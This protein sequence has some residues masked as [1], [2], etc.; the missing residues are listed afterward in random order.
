MVPIGVITT[1]E[2]IKMALHSVETIT[3]KNKKNTSTSLCNANQMHEDN[4]CNVIY[5][6]SL[7]NMMVIAPIILAR[8]SVYIS[9][10]SDNG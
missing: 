6:Q 9:T 8:G 3:T 4:F 5:T 2:K 7:L 10:T 1:S